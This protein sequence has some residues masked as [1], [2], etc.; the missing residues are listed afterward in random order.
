MRVTEYTTV[1]QCGH[2]VLKTI[3]Y[4]S[5]KTAALKTVSIA[6]HTATQGVMNLGEKRRDLTKDM[7]LYNITA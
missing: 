5:T 6:F 7:N 3:Q 1:T 4:I 2:F